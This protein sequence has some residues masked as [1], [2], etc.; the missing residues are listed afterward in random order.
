VLLS[1]VQLSG[2]QARLR[3]FGE[4]KKLSVS[5]SATARDLKIVITRWRAREL[6]LFGGY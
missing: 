4:A 6:K 1:H 5:V 3:S 2:F